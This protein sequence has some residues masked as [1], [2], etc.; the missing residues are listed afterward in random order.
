M[1]VEQPCFHLLGFL[2]A[3]KIFRTNLAQCKF[4]GTTLF[5]GQNPWMPELKG[6]IETLLF[7]VEALSLRTL[8][9]LKPWQP[10]KKSLTT[11]STYSNWNN[12]HALL[13]KNVSEVKLK[14]NCI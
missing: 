9:F 8:P 6:R 11:E 1:L 5:K 10:N 14:T 13:L 3:R 7:K 4:S 12:A 2:A